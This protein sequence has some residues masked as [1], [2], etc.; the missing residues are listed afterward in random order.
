MA[1]CEFIV[2]F[3]KREGFSHFFKSH[4]Q[5]GVGIRAVSRRRVTKITYVSQRDVT[6]KTLHNSAQLA[7]AHVTQDHGLYLSAL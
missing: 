6:A 3:S 1:W 2:L 5:P 4:H 7:R